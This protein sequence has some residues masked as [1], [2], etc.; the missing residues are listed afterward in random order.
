MTPFA[1]SDVV[2]QAAIGAVVTMV[3][4][5]MTHRTRRAVEKTGEATA[6]KADEVKATLETAAK[7]Q[8]ET[9]AIQAKKL[10]AIAT[11]GEKSA[12]TGDKIH[13]LVNSGSLLQLKLN[14]ELSR[15]KAGQTSDP[16]HVAAAEAAEAL[17]RQHERKQMAIDAKADQPPG[18]HPPG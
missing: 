4:A 9:S 16:E 7:E 12:A 13:T 1:V 17:Y 2:Y 10:D 15:W 11:A 3:L 5:Y 6:E 14:A 18:D 8:K